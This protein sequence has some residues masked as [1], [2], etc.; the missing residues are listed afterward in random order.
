MRRH[1]ILQDE[2]LQISIKMQSGRVDCTLAT[3]P[4]H[5]YLWSVLKNEV[6]SRSIGV[7]PFPI[8]PPKVIAQLVATGSS[9]PSSEFEINSR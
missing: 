7:Y 5:P 9:F 1:F 6:L 4:K 8:L 2:N 3:A